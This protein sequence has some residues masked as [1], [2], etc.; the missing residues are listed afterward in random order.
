[1]AQYDLGEIGRFCDDRS[2]TLGRLMASHDG[3]EDDLHDLIVEASGR[4]EL[5]DEVLTALIE[6]FGSHAG[7]LYIQSD[8]GPSQS[9]A[10]LTQVIPFQ[11][12]GAGMM[13]LY[14]EHY[15][16]L[17]PF[18]APGSPFVPGRVL[19]EASLMEISRDFDLAETEFFADWCRP[20]NFHH[21][22]GEILLKDGA[23]LLL[24][25]NRSESAGSYELE[26]QR[27]FHRL[28]RSV[29]SAVRTAERLGEARAELALAHHALEIQRVAVLTLDR[30]MKLRDANALAEEVLRREDGLR[31]RQG[32]IEPTDPKDAVAFRQ[33]IQRV[34]T[35]LY[36]FASPDTSL[37]LRRPDNQF[38][39]QVF[40][41]AT[42]GRKELLKFDPAETA[43]LTFR[44][45]SRNCAP[46]LDSFGAHFR[47]TP[48]EL[49]LADALRDG[50]P[51]PLAAKGLGIGYETARS[52]LKAVFAKTGT[53]RQA[54]LILVIHLWLNSKT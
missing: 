12:Y 18:H 52:Q 24:W 8:P 16:A 22:M 47:L 30:A 31:C 46:D 43:V 25:L 45:T 23:P 38:P 17:N 49:R 53:Q 41:A 29:L 54:E 10:V 35:P 20:Q 2:F 48:S 34:T 27:R 51:L 11:G 1:M 4:P 36:G 32:H 37:T 42:R 26:D 33:A 14:N 39:Y 13:E 44:T 28:S 19:T 7:A 15:H 50:A 21:A 40:V 6:Q 5:W 3:R 9:D